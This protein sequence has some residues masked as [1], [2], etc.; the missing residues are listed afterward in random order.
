MRG[1]RGDA[2]AERSPARDRAGRRS[3]CEDRPTAPL[4]ST[5]Q[6]PRPAAVRPA[7]S[8]PSRQLLLIDLALQLHDAVDERFGARRAAG[9][10][11][12]D[13]HDLIDALN[14]RVVVED[15][16]DRGAS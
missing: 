13:R 3:W 1:P 12:V 14:E 15:A 2:A 4:R 7:T 11:D 9:D 6:E 16:A 5:H 8:S 10:V